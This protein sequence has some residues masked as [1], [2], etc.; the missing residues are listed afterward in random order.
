MVSDK[1]QCLMTDCTFMITFFVDFRFSILINIILH[2]CGMRLVEMGS[3][4]AIVKT[5]VAD[6]TNGLTLILKI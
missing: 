2:S 5:A 4:V 1:K 6:L 3:K